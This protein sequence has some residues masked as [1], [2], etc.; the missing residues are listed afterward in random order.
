MKKCR[1]ILGL[2]RLRVRESSLLRDCYLIILLV[3]SGI[4][5]LFRLRSY[6][7]KI[8]SQV[9]RSACWGF[10]SRLTDSWINENLDLHARVR[11]TASNVDDFLSLIGAGKRII[12][13]K[14]PVSSAEPG[15]LMVMFSETFPLL[16]KFFDME[17][18]LADYILVLE[19]S[20]A[21]YCTADLL[22]YDS[23]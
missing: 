22:H 15:V 11:W 20:W 4:F 13:L 1:I 12:V 3:L 7:F 14:P 10:L 5:R 16:P 19:P 9:N 23:Y 2:I 17:K 21:G 8:Y 6:V 18:L